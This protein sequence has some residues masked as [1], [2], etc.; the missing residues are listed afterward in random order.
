MGLRVQ[1]SLKEYSTTNANKHKR[2]DSAINDAIT[3]ERGCGSHTEV[4]ELY[5][6]C[7]SGRRRAMENCFA[8]SEDKH[9]QIRDSYCNSRFLCSRGSS[10]PSSGLCFASEREDNHITTWAGC[11]LCTSTE[12]IPVGIWGHHQTQTV[13]E[14]LN[15]Q[16]GQQSSVLALWVLR[17]AG[18][19]FSRKVD[20]C[21]EQLTGLLAWFLSSVRESAPREEIP[22]VNFSCS[23]EE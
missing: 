5:L 8:R 22:I 2:L 12:H 13:D 14:Q 4:L 17:P 10:I 9:L 1:L 15:F 6:G 18:T 19:Q 21:L 7:S 23:K 11:I 20:L 16:V 3:F